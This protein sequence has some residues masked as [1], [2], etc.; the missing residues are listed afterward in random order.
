MIFV[1][2]FKLK[3][4]N[5]AKLQIGWL[6][7]LLLVCVLWNIIYKGGCSNI[8]DS[9]PHKFRLLN[10]YV[11]NV[12][13]YGKNIIDRWWKK[14]E[15]YQRLGAQLR[16]KWSLAKINNGVLQY[17]FQKQTSFLPN[18]VFSTNG[19]WKIPGGNSMALTQTRD[20]QLRL[21]VLTLIGSTNIS[22]SSIYI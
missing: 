12:M 20:I 13:T 1:I 22:N 7:L 11:M 15:D 6:L 21:P 9:K 3:F 14:S 17:K 4:T 10:K 19:V 5:D 8:I 18:C 2:Y 16:Q